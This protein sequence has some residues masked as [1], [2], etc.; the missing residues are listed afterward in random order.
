MRGNLLAMAFSLSVV[1]GCGSDDGLS[2]GRKCSDFSHCRAEETCFWPACPGPEPCDWVEERPGTCAASCSEF[3]SQVDCNSFAACEW[4]SEG[5]CEVTVA[6]CDAVGDT[7]CDPLPGD[8]PNYC[9]ASL[10]CLADN[11]CGEC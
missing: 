4:S 9:G 2:Q 8:G 7:C 3:V 10:C 1:A 11:R 5:S 6:G